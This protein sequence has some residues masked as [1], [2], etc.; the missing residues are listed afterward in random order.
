MTTF[1]EH[2]TWARDYFGQDIDAAVLETLAG[3]AGAKKPSGEPKPDGSAVADRMRPDRRRA[4]IRADMRATGTTVL[5]DRKFP[6]HEVERSAKDGELIKMLE[7]IES[8]DLDKATT[9]DLERLQQTLNAWMSQDD[10]QFIDVLKGKATYDNVRAISVGLREIIIDRKLDERQTRRSS[11]A[12]QAGAL[13]G[14]DKTPAALKPAVSAYLVEAKRTPPDGAALQKAIE[15]LKAQGDAAL[16]GAD[17]KQAAAIRALLDNA[18]KELAE[19]QKIDQS[20][21]KLRAKNPA[22][23][24]KSGQEGVISSDAVRGLRI[25][26]GGQR[27]D[28]PL[29]KKG[30]AGAQAEQL[31]DLLEKEAKRSTVYAELLN[32]LVER[33]N[34]EPLLIRLGENAAGFVDSF[35]TMGVDMNDLA[36]LPDD[37]VEVAGPDGRPM[38]GGVTKGE[39]MMHVLEER[40]LMAKYGGYD[41][42]HEACLSPDSFQNRYR[43][44]MGVPADSIIFDCHD[45]GSCGDKTHKHPDKP[46]EAHRQKMDFN[47]YD[48]QGVVMSVGGLSAQKSS[49]PNETYDVPPADATT[50]AHVDLND[51]LDKLIAEGWQLIRAELAKRHRAGQDVKSKLIDWSANPAKALLLGAMS[52]R[53]PTDQLDAAKKK[54]EADAAEELKRLEAEKQ[55]DQARLGD[56]TKRAG[57]LLNAKPDDQ[58]SPES[59]DLR[60]R[61]KNRPPAVNDG[62]KEF[63]AFNQRL[64][65]MAEAEKNDARKPYKLMG[66][67][68]HT[69]CAVTTLGAITNGSSSDFVRD[70][71]TE[72]GLGDIA[73]ECKAYQSETMW[74][75][76]EAGRAWIASSEE[77]DRRTQVQGDAQLRGIR[78]ALGKEAAARNKKSKESGLEFQVVQDGVND[79]GGMHNIDDLMKRMATYPD[80]TQFQ[81][82]IKGD[83]QHWI[84]AE[85]FDGQV[86]FED[87]QTSSTETGKTQTGKVASEGSPDHPLNGRKNA[88]SEGMFIAL[89]PIK[90]GGAVPDHATDPN[91]PDPGSDEDNALM[92]VTRAIAR[93]GTPDKIAAVIQANEEAIEKRKWC[94]PK[95]VAK[96]LLDAVEVQ[97]KLREKQESED[98]IQALRARHRDAL[99]RIK[100]DNSQIDRLLRLNAVLPLET[101]IVAGVISSVELR[102]SEAAIAKLASDSDALIT[103]LEKD[104]VEL[105]EFVDAAEC[106]AL[107]RHAAG[108][109]AKGVSCNDDDMSKSRSSINRLGGLGGK[110]TLPDLRRELSKIKKKLE[111]QWVLLNK[112]VL[113]R[114]E[115]EAAARRAAEE[116][117]AAEPDE[118]VAASPPEFKAPPAP[119]AGGKAAKMPPPPPSKKGAA[120]AAATA[121][122]APP[123]A[124][125]PPPPPAKKGAAKDA[126]AT[127]A[128]APPKAPP[129]PTKKGAAKDA[130]A[131]SVKAPPK[132]PPPPAKKGAAKD[133]K[134]SAS[135]APPKAPPPPPPPK[136]SAAK[137]AARSKSPSRS[138]SP[139]PS[140][141]KR[142]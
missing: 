135:K 67:A 2:A 142:K 44:E 64:Q 18:E 83:M 6:R 41:A 34:I 39:I 87:Y 91:W 15:Q 63:N 111:D 133:A 138:R 1:A 30:T 48:S 136:K 77:G 122:V 101:L 65:A 28:A 37:P 90:K 112:A 7:E 21:A 115:A 45:H 120:K 17:E 16:K 109:I 13:A 27:A 94:Q 26:T 126:S 119:P 95:A 24:P 29:G 98:A 10:R 52:R 59:Q 110:C 35:S 47:A 89:A 11:M 84:Y 79:T 32:D 92:T 86:I 124:P 5:K 134:T 103:A 75:F 19:Y 132:A 69:N 96:A 121:D 53:F 105:K 114:N 60:Q 61:R 51:S 88:F 140:R 113:E 141:S 40:V 106:V 82:F 72:H 46:K 81:V 127:S 93:A 25:E 76:V 57:D 85:K 100:A 4:D 8:I 74:A 102:W 118:V 123:K 9:A 66:D 131:S 23:D 116:E 36:S 31:F 54:L 33:D 130:S 68:E 3:D 78:E 50:C 125:M 108:T 71:M 73:D 139:S 70:W 42:A 55:A 20:M 38:R 56:Q 128:K 43:R 117:A 97:K 137:A 22:W 99:T 14:E 12:E 49:R 107:Y 129:P 80:G 58:L 104:A 62:K